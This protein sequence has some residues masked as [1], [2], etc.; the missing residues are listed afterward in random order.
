METIN[1]NKLKNYLD[2]LLD[3][4]DMV[5]VNGR[6]VSNNDIPNGIIGRIT[7]I[8][9]FNPDTPDAYILYHVY[10]KGIVDE[11]AVFT[12]NNLIKFV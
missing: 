5:I 2:D 10:F 3:S 11:V 8:Q 4:T 7:K 6:P 1:N 12:S 9:H